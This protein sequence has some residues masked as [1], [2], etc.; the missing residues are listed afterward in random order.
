[1]TRHISAVGDTLEIIS[2]RRIVRTL[3]IV[4][5]SKVFRA[6]AVISLSAQHQLTPALVMQFAVSSGLISEVI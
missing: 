3:P 6:P 5:S 4:V 1:M 2:H